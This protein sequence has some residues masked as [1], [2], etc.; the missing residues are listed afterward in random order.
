MA[1]ITKAI[2]ETFPNWVEPATRSATSL[3]C[4]SP[5]AWSL[6]G[7]LIRRL[8]N[9]GDFDAA[10]PPELIRY[11]TSGSSDAQGRAGLT[12][13]WCVQQRAGALFYVAGG[14]IKRP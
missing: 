13:L 5:A 8:A 11:V 2:R 12:P 9:T 1:A 7:P 4:R 3:A 6:S 14:S 10:E